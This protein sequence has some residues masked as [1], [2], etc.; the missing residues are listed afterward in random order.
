MLPDEDTRHPEKAGFGD[1][2]AQVPDK[3]AQ[4]QGRVAPVGEEG[5]NIRHAHT[6]A[7]RFG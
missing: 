6:P 5:S 3:H 4:E 7:A 1:G 2:D